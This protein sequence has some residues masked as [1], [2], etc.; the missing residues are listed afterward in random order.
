MTVN[1]GLKILTLIIFTLFICINDALN[2]LDTSKVSIITGDKHFADRGTEYQKIIG[3][4]ET[5]FY[6]LRKE[7][8]YVLE[9]YDNNLNMTKEVY[10]KL[11]KGLTTFELEYA[12]LFHGKLYLFTSTQNIKKKVLHV[13]TVDK[14]TLEQ[15]EDRR[16]FSEF[17]NFSGNWAD[18]H[19]VLSKR[20]QKLMVCGQILAFWKRSIVQEM[21]VLDKDLSVDWKIKKTLLFDQRLPAERKFHIDDAGNVYLLGQTYQVGLFNFQLDQK[22]QFVIISYT[23][24]GD[25]INEYYIKLT[26]KF[27][28]ELLMESGND[29]NLFCAGL[30]SER[31]RHGVSGAIC[32][33][34]D[35]KINK[36]TGQNYVHLDPDQDKNILMPGNGTKQI[37]VSHKSNYLHVRKNGNF[38]FTVEQQLNQNYDNFNEILLFCF[39]QNGTLAW[40]R[41]ILKKQTYNELSDNN[42]CSYA[43]FAPLDENT[44]EILYNDNIKNYPIKENKKL[45][46]F[47]PSAKSY[48]IQVEID[49][50]GQASK[51]A[52]MYR[53]RRRDPVPNV[54]EFYDTKTNSII[55]LN[56]RH[57][58]YKYS[59]L[60]F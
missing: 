14:S 36:I 15:N 39:R 30:Y 26:G 28:R 53:K 44:V 25:N 49:E 10:P 56:E 21:F 13:E 37:L 6:V 46:T 42:F 45:R 23:N 19:F 58:K 1:K 22:N 57:I 60:S 20:E 18:I 40:R 11:Y 27:I 54:L 2:Q 35:N 48:L 5:G 16:V 55:L 12:V 9:H 7:F 8:R 17:P 31:A 24:K 59:K 51:H 29:N 38:I 3:Y 47:H 52:I 41:T 33:T 32:F 34:V 50:F 4:D 43:L